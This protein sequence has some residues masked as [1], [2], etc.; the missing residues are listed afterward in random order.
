MNKS[1]REVPRRGQWW[2]TGFLPGL[3][4]A[5][6]SEFDHLI[7]YHHRQ[8]SF[9]DSE[10]K[11]F[12]KELEEYVQENQLDGESES[13]YYETHEDKLYML[14]SFFPIALRHSV[15]VLMCT[16]FESKLTEICRELEKS[17]KG[18]ATITWKSLSRDKGVN[19]AASFF[20]GKYNIHI[21]GNL[22]WEGI[23]DYFKLRHCIAHANGAIE[24]MKEPVEIRRIVQ[25]YRDQ[26]L[27]ETKENRLDPGH[28]FIQLAI[29]SMHTFF[30]EL[31]DALID[32]KYVGPTFWP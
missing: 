16:L 11:R 20:R 21:V 2:A 24:L 9:I 14:H 7:E 28:T 13:A 30:I 25:K 32:N 22:C 26:G 19:R 6:I 18:K 29:S 4:Y 17:V 3:L 1:T 12:T 8:N 23:V 10:G 31:Q 15:F 27:K 5:A